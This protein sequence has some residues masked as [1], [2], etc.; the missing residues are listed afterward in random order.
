M[1]RRKAAAIGRAGLRG[2]RR[3]WLAIT[4]PIALVVIAAYAVAFMLDEPLRR[5][6][7]GKMNRALKGYTARIK[8]LDF[9]SAVDVVIRLVQNAFFKSIL[10]G[11]DLEVARSD[12]PKK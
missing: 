5:Y 2:I 10:P 3:H 1:V 4:V 11:F 8:T 7:E 12:H 6:T 9:V